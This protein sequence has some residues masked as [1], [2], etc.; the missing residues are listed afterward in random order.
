MYG[1]YKILDLLSFLKEEKAQ[2]Y[3]LQ[4]FV[5]KKLPDGKDI[6]YY[7]KEYLNIKYHFKYT[8]T[9]ILGIEYCNIILSKKPIQENKILYFRPKKLGCKK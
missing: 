9:E 2:I 4:E 5:N 6:L 1:S 3:V 7:F 8:I